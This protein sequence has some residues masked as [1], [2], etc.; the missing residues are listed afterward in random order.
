MTLS[1]RL[2]LIPFLLAFFVQV[3]L[4]AQDA[5]L[6]LA[7]GKEAFKEK[8]YEQAA[9]LFEQV[10]KQDK[11]NAEAWYF[12]GYSYSRVNSQPAERIPD[13]DRQLVIKSTDA[14]QKSIKLKPVYDGERL[15]L[16]PYSKITAEWGN[17]ALKYW[18][19]GRMDSVRWA[20]KQGKK[21]GGF[22]TFFLA[23]AQQQL[24]ECRPNALLFSCGDNVFFNA[25]Y[26]QVMKGLRTDVK[27]IETN[28][29]HSFWYPKALV[30]YQKVDFGLDLQTIDTI[31]Y[32]EWKDQEVSIG[33]LTWTIK[34]Y[35]KSGFLLRG[36]WL[37]YQFLKQNNFVRPCH[38][39]SG[40]PPDDQIGL[41]DWLVCDGRL[42]TYLT[43]EK[44]LFNYDPKW[45]KTN[46]NAIVGLCKHLSKKSEDEYQTMHIYFM[47]QLLQAYKF[48]IQGEKTG[49]K[50][51]LVELKRYLD[52]KFCPLLD[53]ELTQMAKEY[54]NRVE[55][56]VMA[57]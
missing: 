47:Q 38:F 19:E 7:Q 5:K 9:K 52:G 50:E 4:Q 39:T 42:T 24:L 8:E 3:S 54:Y 11:K 43:T 27:L 28:L 40:F 29:L 45:F 46:F 37:M 36:N 17:L 16:D 20:L 35:Q 56:R 6:L 25:F 34:S 53:N 57:E 22:S 55:K 1:F 32:F 48:Y 12:L 13:M 23:H 31:P 33:E 10:V 41:G 21:R 44:V 2:S 14:L 26:L 18:S 15:P 30:K 51:M 49:A